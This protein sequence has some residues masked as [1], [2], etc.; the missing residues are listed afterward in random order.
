[1]YVLKGPDRLHFKYDEEMI[2]DISSD[3]YYYPSI[4]IKYPYTPGTYLQSLGYENELRTGSFFANVFDDGNYY[5]FR[6]DNAKDIAD[7]IGNVSIGIQARDM[8][9]LMAFEDYLSSEASDMYDAADPRNF[10]FL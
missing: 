7:K 8:N 2:F 1:M 3:L 4:N 10:E 6:I 5:V 9:V